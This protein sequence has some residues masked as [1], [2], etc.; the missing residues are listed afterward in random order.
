MFA[1]VWTTFAEADGNAAGATQICWDAA[2]FSDRVKT[3]D[4]PPC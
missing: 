2:E 3:D 4:T 1:V